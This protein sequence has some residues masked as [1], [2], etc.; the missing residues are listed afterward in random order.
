MSHDDEDIRYGDGV[1]WCGMVS[2]GDDR[3]IHDI[4]MGNKTINLV[5]ILNT[6]PIW[7]AML[8]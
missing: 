3:S 6:R 8:E 7:G 2:L 4:S 5:G 1:L